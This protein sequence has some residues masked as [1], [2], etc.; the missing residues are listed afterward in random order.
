MVIWSLVEATSEGIDEVVKF[1]C[2]E[3]VSSESED[4][5]EMV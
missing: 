5:E 1:V 2:R 3:A 4:R